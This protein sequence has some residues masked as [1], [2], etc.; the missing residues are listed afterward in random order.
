MCLRK[1]LNIRMH[2]TSV[3][4]I[5]VLSSL[6]LAACAAR[7][8][9][10]SGET[11]DTD[12]ASGGADITVASPREGETVKSPL[13]VEGRARG[14]W[15]FEA[16]FPVRLL[17]ADGSELAAVPAQA[18]GEWMTQSFV[19][20]RATLTFT[21]SAAQSGTLVLL[22]DNPSGEPSRDASLRIP[23]RIVP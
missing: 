23:V 18:Q 15:Y 14:T 5:V 3:R 8:P 11:G 7:G 19:P 17:D 16:S 20:F 6:A 10:A 13:V 21:V 9:A 4:V 22:K 2:R 12:A 1:R